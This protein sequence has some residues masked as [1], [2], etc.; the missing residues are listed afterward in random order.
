MF[1]SEEKSKEVEYCNV[2]LLVLSPDGVKVI[3]EIEE[4]DITP[5]QIC[6]KFLASALSRYFI[7]ERK[8]NARIGMSDSALF[9][10]ILNT[11]GLKKD[12]TSKIQQWKNIE[13]SIQ[14][15]TPI[16]GSRIAHCKLLCGDADDF[17]SGHTGRRELID[18]IQAHLTE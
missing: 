16:K 2:D 12:K 1:S 7:H 5:I 13:R 10:Q 4:A 6:G 17:V 9:I 14:A 3:V 11:S 15:A 18:C 8:Q